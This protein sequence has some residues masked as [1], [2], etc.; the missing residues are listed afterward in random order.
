MLYVNIRRREKET[1]AVF[2]AIITENYP[3]I[4]VRHQTT[5][6]GS[7]EDTKQHK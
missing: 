1:E 7:L 4:N 5:D 6:P 3:Q 2:E